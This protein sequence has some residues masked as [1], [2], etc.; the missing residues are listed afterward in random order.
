[1]VT[2]KSPGLTKDGSLNDV[3]FWS[4]FVGFLWF[5]LEDDLETNI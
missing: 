2:M 3:V 4:F 5:D 1:M